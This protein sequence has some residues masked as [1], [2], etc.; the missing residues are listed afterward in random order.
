MPNTFSPDRLA[1]PLRAW[2]L[3]RCWLI[4]RRAL[5]GML[6]VMPAAPELAAHGRAASRPVAKVWPG[7]RPG[8]EDG[9]GSGS[10][11][12]PESCPLTVRDGVA[13]LNVAGPIM[14]GGSPI[15]D[16]FCD[17]FGGTRLNKLTCELDCALA[18][19]DVRGILLAVDSPGG[20]VTGVSEFA[21]LVRDAGGRKPVHAWV[22]G[23]ACS[24][25]YWIASAA[26][27][28]TIAPT[29]A[30]GSIGVVIVVDDDTEMM[31]RIGIKE[32]EFVSDHAPDKRPDPGTQA[33]RRQF[34]DMANAVE[35]VFIA[36]VAANRKV[37]EMK[38]IEDFGAGG[39]VIGQEAV[40]VG[41][42]DA[43]GTF[44]ESLAG[45]TNALASMDSVMRA[46]IMTDTSR[47]QATK[48]QTA[49]SADASITKSSRPL[50]ASL[51][52]TVVGSRRTKVVIHKP[53]TVIPA[54][55]RG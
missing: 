11:D 7:G 42:A 37:S 41:M 16:Y 9:G 6:A 8:P 48:S 1:T 55:P 44:A 45:V 31:S 49:S 29:S 4:D 22:A 43:V 51:P 26:S 27:K 5:D 24:A 21:G 19:P 17:T 34:K 3:G 30:V 54:T 15:G 13:V 14:P 2:A 50:V 36:D 23:Q 47:P 38:V 46:G 40:K 39:I 52:T 53:T 18:R 28:V 32:Y 10:D 33:G 25:A 20:E 12:G 35:G